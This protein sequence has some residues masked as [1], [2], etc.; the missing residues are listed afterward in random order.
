MGRIMCWWSNHLQCHLQGACRPTCLLLSLKSWGK[1][2]IHWTIILL[3]LCVWLQVC[4]LSWPEILCVSENFTALALPNEEGTWTQLTQVYQG[5]C[6]KAKYPDDWTLLFEQQNVK[7][8]ESVIKLK[9]HTHKPHSLWVQL[10]T[11]HITSV[12]SFLDDKENGRE[13]E[14]EEKVE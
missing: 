12:L 11:L 8:K 7:K 10:A 5:A 13:M 4:I 9:T 3:C 14:V 2:Q 1:T 6:Q